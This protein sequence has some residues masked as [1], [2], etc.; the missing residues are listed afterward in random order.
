MRL[1]L[2][3]HFEPP[4]L[5]PYDYPHYLYS[6]LLNAIKLAD[7]EV[8]SRIHNNKRDIK[9]VASKFK[10]VGRTKRVNEGLLVES[11]TVELHVASTEKTLLRVL[12]EGLRYGIGELHVRGQG[13]LHYEPKLEKTPEHLSGKRFK[14]LSP[15]NVYYNNPPNGLKQWDLSPVGQPNSPFENE[16]E[17]WK[18]LVFE[19]LKSKYLMV[20]GEPYNGDFDI[21]VLTKKPKSKKFFIKRDEKTGKPI[22]TRAWEFDFKMWGE[23]EVLRV[24][25]DLGLGMRNPHGFGMIEMEKGLR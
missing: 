16:P 14:T 18:R 6:F 10:P 25:Y 5:I 1:T 13:L 21:K 2:I 8:A 9:F 20:Y 12:G 17:V 15:V 19:N 4:F 22:Y 11:G 3:L 7:R 24:A 23:E